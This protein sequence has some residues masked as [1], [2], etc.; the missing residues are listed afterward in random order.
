MKNIRLIFT[1]LLIVLGWSSCTKTIDFQEAEN[2]QQLIINGILTPDS[3]FKIMLVK[4]QSI[5]ESSGYPV[6]SGAQVT[7][8]E[9]GTELGQAIE[10]NGYYTIPAYRPLPG[11]TYRLDVQSGSKNLTTETYIPTSAKIISVDTTTNKGQWGHKRKQFDLTFE[12]Q[13]GDDF[14]RI[15]L[16]QELLYT[17]QIK[18][19]S[20]VYMLSRSTQY[21]LSEDPVFNSL[22]NNIDNETLDMGPENN[23]QIFPDLYFNNKQ[24]NVKFEVY[25]SY[26][27]ND[28]LYQKS[29]VHLQKL[30]KDLFNFLKYLNLHNY[31]RDEPFSEPVPVYSNIENGTGIFAGVNDEAQVSF[32]EVFIPHSMD[33]IEVVEAPDYGYGG[34]YGGY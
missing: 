7:L 27:N 2:E 4:S 15:L 12:D 21:I 28:I 26:R 33:T 30:S 3:T 8:K 13:P 14:Y 16:V 11:K 10:K 29:T 6:V 25:D 1:C 23:Y 34:Y 32:K 18:P 22:Y 20:M 24:Y 9:D 19:D 17:M 31:Y 5:L